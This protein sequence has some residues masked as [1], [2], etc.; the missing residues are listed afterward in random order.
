MTNPLC[1][2]CQGSGV[3]TRILDAHDAPGVGS[4]MIFDGVPCPCTCYTADE[5]WERR[6][7]RD[8][9]EVFGE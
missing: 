1:P 5:E 8:M 7:E 3:V 4:W 6:L 2:K 9:S